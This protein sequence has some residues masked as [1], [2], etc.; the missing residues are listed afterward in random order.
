MLARMSIPP[1]QPGHPARL[2][3]DQ[4]RTDAN[5]Q[6][7]IRLHQRFS[8][9]RHGWPRWLFDQLDLHEDARVLELGCG[10]GV[11]WA[12]N[13]HRIPPG[14]QVVLSDRSPGMLAAV[15]GPPVAVRVV[16]DA[17]AVPFA[18]ASFDVVLANHMLYHVPDRDRAL[19]EI[20]RVLRPGGQVYAATN[21]RRHLAELHARR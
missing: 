20:H 1:T 14:W 2:G 3:S 12:T 7:R 5:L 4:Y 13:T 9:N 6:A 16:A 21:G 10:T 17:Q 18:P 8:T 19:G 11:L 15:A